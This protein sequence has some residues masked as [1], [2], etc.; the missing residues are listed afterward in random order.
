MSESK[1][2]GAALR[3]V[4]AARGCELR[5][6]EARALADSLISLICTGV[7]VPEVPEAVHQAA[8]RPSPSGLLGQAACGQADEETAPAYNMGQSIC[9]DG[10]I[11]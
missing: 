5:A 7:I 9:I 8:G 3:S 6:D 10:D 4:L 1:Q 11:R 2:P